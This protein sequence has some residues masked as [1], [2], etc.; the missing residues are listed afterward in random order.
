MRSDAR[1]PVRNQRYSNVLSFVGLAALLLCVTWLTGCAG[2]S[3]AGSGDTTT[4]HL[5]GRLSSATMGLPYNGT[6]SVI[7]G[8]APYAFRLTSGSLPTGLT[9][10]PNGGTISGTPGKSGVYNFAVGVADSKNSEGSQSFQ[11]TVNTVGSINVTVSPAVTSV[12]SS[13][14]LQFT[15]A[16]ANSS[17][18][19]VTWSASRGTIS[20][21]G[22]YQAPSVS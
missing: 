6:I 20:S 21:S 10:S 5:S 11:I 12:S 17:N 13:G 22:L 9:L 19:A 7:G 8:T 18:V 2:V 15:A 1:P 16:V 14:T 3:A 4:P